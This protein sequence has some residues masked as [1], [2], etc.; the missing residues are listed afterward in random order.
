M[1]GLYIARFVDPSGGINQ[2]YLHRITDLVTHTFICGAAGSGKTVMGKILVEEAGRLGVPAIVVD[3]KG[4]LSSLALAFS[5]SSARMLAPWIQ[6][7]DPSMLGRAA[8]AEANV[9]RKRLADWALSEADVRLFS[10]KVAVDFTPPN[11]SGRRVAIPLI[12]APPPDIH[13]LFET[14]L[15]SAL[16]MVSSLAEALVRR[17]IPTAQRDREQEYVTL[18]HSSITPGVTK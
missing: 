1:S 17:V 11:D 13:Q 12:P 10:E 4:D 9:V 3:L 15:D 6:V 7:E 14:D 8:L 2:R 18:Q 5:E 16:I